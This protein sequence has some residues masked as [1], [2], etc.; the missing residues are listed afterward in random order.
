[1]RNAM[2]RNAMSRSPKA[3]SSELQLPVS[4]R[5]SRAAHCG[6][7]ATSEA[8]GDVGRRAHATGLTTTRTGRR[9]SFLVSARGSSLATRLA[10]RMCSASVALLTL[11]SVTLISITPLLPHA[12][13]SADEEEAPPR[14]PPGNETTAEP[15][16]EAGAEEQRTQPWPARARLVRVDGHGVRLR[17]GPRVDVHPILEL[18][19]H[20]PLIELRRLGSWAGVLVPA[21][22]PCVISSK[23]S[24]VEDEHT[25]VVTGRRVNLRVRV[26]EEGGP[27]P[28]AFRKQ[29]M[30]DERLLLLPHAAGIPA[31]A[32][33]YRIMAP[34]EVEAWIHTDY[35]RDI[36]LADEHTDIIEAELAKRAA[37][38]SAVREARTAARRDVQDKKLLRA[39]AATEKELTAL[40]RVGGMDR[41]PVIRLADA[42]VDS[43][44]AAPN[45]SDRVLRLG[46]ALYK[47]LEAEIEIRVARKDAEVARLRG[48]TVPPLKPVAPT[49]PQVTAE[50]TLLHEE[51]PGW[52]SGHL[53]V[54]FKGVEPVYVLRLSTETPTPWPNLRKLADGTTHYRVEGKAPGERAFGLPVIEVMRITPTDE[55]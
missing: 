17:V 15:A 39:L 48:L 13:A 45:A 50:G 25:V 34:L 43:L 28:G 3:E 53:Y 30:R 55:R 20:T 4:A 51:A 37:A 16:S 11:M 41:T 7:G 2:Y 6:E 29:A 46:K 38:L 47:D 12:P 9:A 8:H 10:R 21:G 44:A 1:M 19:R 52:S 40:R 33:W 42:L 26:P 35:L 18:D 14:P 54:F 23:Y 24:R 31:D 36:G 32:P 27:L 22:F 5:P 49:I